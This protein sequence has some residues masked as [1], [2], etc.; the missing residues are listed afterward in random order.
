MGNARDWGHS[1]DWRG[2][3]CQPTT[4]SISVK[5]QPNVT[6][7]V[8][9]WAITRGACLNPSDLTSLLTGT[10]PTMGPAAAADSRIGRA[11]LTL[12]FGTNPDLLG[13]EPSTIAVMASD[14]VD[15]L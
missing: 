11:M 8:T 6:V 5:S 10:W 12:S 2:K 7:S 1:G 4:T 9:P 13:Q 14:T 3:G 15:V